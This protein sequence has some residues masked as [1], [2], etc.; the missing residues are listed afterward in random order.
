M[1]DMM[2]QAEKLRVDATECKLI[3]QLATTPEQR[4]LFARLAEHLGA[5]ASEVELAIAQARTAS[6]AEANSE[7]G[8]PA[9]SRPSDS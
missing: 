4:A 9:A 8:E 2:A 7:N 1:K 6:E 5:L 3:S